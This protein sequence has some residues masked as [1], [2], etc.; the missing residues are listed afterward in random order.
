MPP[1]RCAFYAD[2]LQRP[3]AR[4]EWETGAAE[5]AAVRVCFAL[6]AVAVLLAASNS[7]A[8][9]RSTARLRMFPSI[10]G[11]KAKLRWDFST[12]G[13]ILELRPRGL[14]PSRQY[15]VKI[16]SG[17]A[18]SFVTDA[19]GSADV[20]I[21]LADTAAGIAPTHDPRGA[22]VL[23]AEVPYFG[24][25]IL[26]AL[27][28]D[29]PQNDLPKSR[30]VEETSLR[31]E[32]GV[33]GTATSLYR[34]LPNG[35]DKLTV[36]LAGVSGGDFEIRISGTTVASVTSDVRGG[37]RATL[38]SR[39]T[40][41]RGGAGS[42][43]PHKFEG[44]LAVSARN[45][46]VEVWSAGALQFSGT[47]IAQIPGLNACTP[48][49]RSVA[50]DREPGFPTGSA[51]VGLGFETNCDVHHTL[52]LVDLPAGSYYWSIV[53]GVGG[54]WFFAIPDSGT[55]IGSITLEYEEWPDPGEEWS[56]PELR[57]GASFEIQQQ[58]AGGTASL[59]FSG[60]LP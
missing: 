18:G 59:A 22:A 19:R 31:P 20:R 24:R 40:V 4:A 11:A 57:S 8:E 47:T 2:L 52:Q 54:G 6:A 14:D 34:R 41:G 21:D 35:G 16:D 36:S 45:A 13:A 32:A 15:F 58:Q 26:T 55:G 28:L 49:S 3:Q 48:T 60:V 27:V 33:A 23:I 29:I 43:S 10:P 12:A 44:P 38:S 5:G 39:S 56:S 37:A 46:Q 51:T 53:G 7:R 30:H 50:L 25:Q 17:I 42:R 9:E 1:Q